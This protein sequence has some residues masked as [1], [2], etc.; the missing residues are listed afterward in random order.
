MVDVQRSRFFLREKANL[1]M[2]RY[3]PKASRRQPT[4]APPMAAARSSKWRLEDS[5]WA[6]RKQWAESRDYWDTSEVV[7]KA[8]THDWRKAV[9]HNKLDAFLLKHDAGAPDPKLCTREVRAAFLDEVEQVV[10]SHGRMLLQVFD[11]YASLG[12]TDDL[13]HIYQLG[14]RALISD[15]GLAV[16]GS[17]VCDI[18]SYDI[19]FLLANMP[20][21]QVTLALALTHTHTLALTLT[22]HPSPSPSPL[23][24]HLL[25]GS[26]EVGDPDLLE[27]D[28]RDDDD[29]QDTLR[30]HL[31]AC[32][33]AYDRH[34]LTH[35]LAHSRY[36]AS[37]DAPYSLTHL[38]TH[39]TH[40]LTHLRYPASRGAP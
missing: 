28:D 3:A 15:C 34:S 22:H 19:I 40:L 29:V 27:N 11:Y 25:V 16:D 31:N 4:H 18:N 5:I 21:A 30:A 35:S 8:I 26:E 9:A 39:I 6:G 36:P 23:T 20:D 24:L 13:F 17:R 32:V 38:L 37:R 2:V 33:C 10:L 12:V 1:N 14:Y 7:E